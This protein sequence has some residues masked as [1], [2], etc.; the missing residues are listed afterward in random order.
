MSYQRTGCSAGSTAVATLKLTNGAPRSGLPSYVT[1]WATTPPKGI[2]PGD[3]LLLVTYYASTG[4]TIRSVTVDGKPITLA[5][6]TENGLVTVSLA[7][8]LPVGSTHTISVTTTEPAASSPV[9]ILRQPLALPL[10]VDV[11][12]DRCG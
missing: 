9:Q 6:A 1:T 4:A 3:N 2:K 12:G 10:H 8:L 5:S 11:S 7:L